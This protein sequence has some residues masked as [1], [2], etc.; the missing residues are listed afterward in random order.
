MG[1]CTVC[2]TAIQQLRPGQEVSGDITATLPR[3]RH[4]MMLDCWI[5]GK[6]SRWL[7]TEDQISFTKWR[8]HELQVKYS[9]AIRIS[10]D[11]PRDDIILPFIM[12]ISPVGYAEEKSEGCTVALNFVASQGKN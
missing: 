9:G 12:M 2:Y 4:E 10:L 8:A 7:E 1:L 6:V 5:C 3:Y 11:K